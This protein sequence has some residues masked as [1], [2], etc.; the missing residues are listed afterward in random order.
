MSLEDEL[1]RVGGEAAALMRSKDW[2]RSPLGPV[3]SWSQALRTMVGLLLRNHSPMLL[4][5][6]H[7]FVQLYNDAY[8][9]V[10]G[11]KHPRSMGQPTSECWSEI[12]HVIG[13]MIEAP[14]RG[15]PATTSD[16]LFLLL[17]RKDF[18]EETHFR[19][20][21]S[22][23][24]DATVPDTGIGGV[25]ATVAETTEQVYAERQ[26]RTLRELGAR[27][28]AEAKTSEAACRAAA[29]T[30]CLLY[31]SDAADERSSVDLGG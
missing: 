3:E 25:L 11:S 4:W 27:G 29:A 10:L 1:F 5:W 31:T 21:Y 9:P 12:F 17:E 18:V 13:P 14:F 20:A 26:L 23:V 24:P 19:V 7:E 30:L 28:T 22:P 8:R 16:D 6:G 2:S 15:G